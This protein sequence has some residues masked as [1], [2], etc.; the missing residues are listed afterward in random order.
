MI[1]VPLVELNKTLLEQEAEIERLTEECGS[2][3]QKLSKDPEFIRLVVIS[4]LYAVSNQ[5]LH[6]T[7]EFS[8]CE[9][10]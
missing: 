4:I 10:K 3:S 6:L 1:C 8:A 9:L 2:M 7:Q 5:A